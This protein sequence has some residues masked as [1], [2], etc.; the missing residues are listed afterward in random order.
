[1]FSKLLRAEAE[2]H[3]VVKIDGN[4]Q[5]DQEIHVTCAESKI[6]ETDR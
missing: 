4:S 1:M 2:R 5:T 3:H 6:V